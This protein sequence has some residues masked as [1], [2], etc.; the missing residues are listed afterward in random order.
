MHTH[1]GDEERHDVERLDP[2]RAED[3]I[4][5]RLAVEYACGEEDEDGDER[6]GDVIQ[7][8][9][10]SLAGWGVTGIWFWRDSE[11]GQRVRDSF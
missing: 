9:V 5:E 6:D 11:D 4:A 3:A 8:N 7:P 10:R 2:S 1:E